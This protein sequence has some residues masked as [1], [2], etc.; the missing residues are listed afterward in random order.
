MTDADLKDIVGGSRSYTTTVT[1]TFSAGK[2]SDGVN[3]DTLFAG[4]V[5]DSTSFKIGMPKK[6]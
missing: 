5:D 6:R 4:T 3:N 2:L 1:D